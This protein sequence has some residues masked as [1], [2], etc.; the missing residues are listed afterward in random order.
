MLNSFDEYYYDMN[1]KYLLTPWWLNYLFN[2]RSLRIVLKRS[3]VMYK[4]Y[5]LCQNHKT[6]FEIIS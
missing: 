1:G 3:A 6:N 5:Y 2:L 4:V